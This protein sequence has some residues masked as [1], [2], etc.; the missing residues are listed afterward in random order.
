ML[1]LIGDEFGFRRERESVEAIEIAPSELACIEAVAGHY[2]GQKCPK[3]R[4]SLVARLDHVVG[5]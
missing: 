4:G 2:F 1:D 3:S 5:R